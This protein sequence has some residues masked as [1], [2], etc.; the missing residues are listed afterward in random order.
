MRRLRIIAVAGARG[1]QRSR[2]AQPRLAHP[3]GGTGQIQSLLHQL[4]F[5]SEFQH[6]DPRLSHLPSSLTQPGRRES[7]VLPHYMSAG[8]VRRTGE[9]SSVHLGAG[10]VSR[11]GTLFG[12]GRR[13]CVSVN[14]SGETEQRRREMLTRRGGTTSNSAR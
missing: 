13:L 12:L 10:S 3:R 4:A 6:Y 1:S 9:R 14:Q 8:K 2:P 11:C 7:A 5:E